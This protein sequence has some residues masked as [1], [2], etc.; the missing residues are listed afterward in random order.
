MAG[1][2]VDMALVFSPT[3]NG[4]IVILAMFALWLAVGLTL[5][6]IEKCVRLTRQKLRR[7]RR[8]SRR[9]RRNVK[10]A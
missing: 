9:N 2:L 8:T 7:S 3:V 4:V 5:E 6:G 1:K 10:W